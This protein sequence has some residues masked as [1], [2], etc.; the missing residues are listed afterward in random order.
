ME[1]VRPGAVIGSIPHAVDRDERPEIF[2]H[3]LSQDGSGEWRQTFKL[4]KDR[5]VLKEPL[6]REQTSRFV[7]VSVDGIGMKNTP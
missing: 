2:Y 7:V 5:I 6:D 1:N 3:I 4:K